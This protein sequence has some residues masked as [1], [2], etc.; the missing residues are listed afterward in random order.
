MRRERRLRRQIHVPCFLFEFFPSGPAELSESVQQPN[1]CQ[2]FQ[3]GLS[4]SV[5]IKIY[6]YI[7]YR[8]HSK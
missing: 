7:A 2:H 5:S 6:R 3:N 4:A 8:G 1:L